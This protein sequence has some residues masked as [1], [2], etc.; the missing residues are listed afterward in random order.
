MIFKHRNGYWDLSG[1]ILIAGILNVT[2]DSFS[3]GRKFFSLE[4]ALT[5]A[6]MM[7]E[8]GADL[9]D[10]GGES[11]RP[12]SDS[13]SANEEINR[14]IPLIKALKQSPK[15]KNCIISIDTTKY[16][17]AKAAIDEGVEIINDISA[18]R[19][20]ERMIKLASES[21]AGIILMHMQGTPKNMQ[22]A[23]VYEDVISEILLFLEEAKNKAVEDGIDIENIV[24]DPGIGFGKSIEDNFKIISEINYF[25]MKLNRPILIGASRKSFIGRTL[26]LPVEERLIGSITAAVI[27][28]INGASILRVHDVKETRQAIT[29]LDKVYSYKN[30]E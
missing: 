21:G 6:V 18:F 22:I 28:A 10:I 1:K 19:N 24:L 7:V 25:R 26:N 17:V 9:I 23:P 3:D 13:I 20:D 2:P 27:S 16:E 8:E 14:V 29:I 15:T 12:G 30:Q 4:D 5:R 11:T